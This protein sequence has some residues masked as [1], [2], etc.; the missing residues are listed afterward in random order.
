MDERVAVRKGRTL[1][2]SPEA[3]RRSL[4]A[5][6]KRRVCRPRPLPSLQRFDLNNGSLER[7][8]EFTPDDAA[9]QAQ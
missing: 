2:E 4:L 3:A 5:D 8:S 6:S 7:I 9:R 1:P